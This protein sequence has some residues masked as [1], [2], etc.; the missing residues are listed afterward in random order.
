VVHA[1]EAVAM[2]KELA[3]RALPEA[4]WS[5]LRWYRKYFGFLPAVRAYLDLRLNGGIAHAPNTV[6]GRAVLL[7]PG[8]ADQDVYSEIFLTSEYDLDLGSPRFILDAG[9]H[10]G[11]SAVFFACKYPSAT[12]VALEPEPSNFEMLLRNTQSYRN[13]RPLRVGLW[14]NRTYLQIADPDVPTWSFRVGAS[15]VDGGIP[16]V[17]IADIMLDFNVSTIDVAKIDVEGAEVEVLSNGAEWLSNVGALIIELHD[18]FRPGCSEALTNALRGY[19]YRRTT[20]GES[21]I[22]TQICRKAHITRP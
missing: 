8:T 18:R 3:K 12:I 11:L 5:F 15:S 13:V 1:A 19:D 6:G 14:R 21:E 17:G 7:R 22:V 16:A 4:H 9:A 10:I 20:S 2:I